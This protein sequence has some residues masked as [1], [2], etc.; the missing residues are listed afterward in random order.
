MNI[1]IEYYRPQGSHQVLP[2][3]NF[4]P[5]GIV[6]A[7][8]CVHLCVNAFVPVVEAEMSQKLSY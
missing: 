2:E 6:I 3:A 8:V 1:W 7:N 4:L 5:S